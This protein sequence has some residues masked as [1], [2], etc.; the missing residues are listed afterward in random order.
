MAR[1]LALCAFCVAIRGDENWTHPLLS[2][3]MDGRI[4]I[5]N[6]GKYID[7]ITRPE[8]GVVG[9][10]EVQSAADYPWMTCYLNGVRHSCGGALIHSEWV[11]TAAHCGSS[12]SGRQFSFGS[13]Q[14]TAA[15][16]AEII[17]VQQIYR[18]PSYNPSSL[19]FDGALARLGARLQFGNNVRPVALA[20]GSNQFVGYDSTVTGWGTTRSGGSATQ[21][22]REVTYPIISNSECS[23]MY[24]GITDDMLCS[25][26][27]GGG[28]DACQGD[29]GGP[30]VVQEAGN[31]V[32]VGIVSWGQG[33]AGNRAPGVYGRTSEM[34]SWI[35][36]TCD[37]C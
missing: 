7:N 33:C 11:L 28:K 8:V 16:G 12:A 34:H 13:T 24:S 15:G 30:L 9:G 29:S 2:R 1:T 19:Q 14:Y 35:C 10:T 4:D 6:I 31:W 25:Y 22:L 3:D 5:S 23:T 32:H 26:T 21:V 18:H 36:S 37:C 17:N 20:S 27:P